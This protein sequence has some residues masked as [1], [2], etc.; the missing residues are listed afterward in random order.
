MKKLFSI[1][2]MMLS[3]SLMS[4]AQDG[5]KNVAVE[6]FTYNSSIGTNWVS[7][8]RNNII[9]GISATTRVNVVDATTLTSLPKD[10]EERLIALNEQGVDVVL[11]CQFNSLTTALDKDKKYYEC[12]ASYTITLTDVTG[13]TIISTTPFNDEWLVG[14]TQS[15]AI[16]KCLEYATSNMK[17]FVDDNFKTE[18]IIKQLDQVD[19]KKGVQTAYVSVGSNAGITSGQMFDVMEEVEIAGEKATKKIG[20]AK[21]Q[22]VVSGTL[23]LVKI[24]KGG[25]DIKKAFDA[26]HTLIVVSRAKKDLLGGFGIKL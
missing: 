24:T 15:E 20:D 1:V 4:F 9:S 5:K 25:V 18:A 3:A 14:D 19:A 2:L 7:N 26:G 8:L 10:K 16:T 13:G 6:D 23:T 11:N 17:K 21:A 22:E 12:K